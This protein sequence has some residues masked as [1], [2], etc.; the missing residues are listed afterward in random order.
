MHGYEMISELAERTHGAWRPSP[1]SVY[2]MLQVLQEEGLV[3]PDAAEEGRRSYRLTAAGR[4]LVGRHSELPPWAGL[5]TPA[6]PLDARLREV[7]AALAGAVDQVLLV[8]STGQKERAVDQLVAARRAMYAL[9]AEDRSPDA[10]S[11][12]RPPTPR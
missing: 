6:D 4:E 5:T 11:H 12:E 1:G 3:A 2:P 7:M 8:A 10:E 9:L